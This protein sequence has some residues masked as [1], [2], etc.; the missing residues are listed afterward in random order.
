MHRKDSKKELLGE[1]MVPL[2]SLD[3]YPWWEKRGNMVMSFREN[4]GV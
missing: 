2:G 4:D 3:T 1:I